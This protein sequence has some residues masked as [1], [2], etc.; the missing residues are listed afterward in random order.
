ML[1]RLCHGDKNGVTDGSH[2]TLRSLERMKGQDINNTAYI[3][4][5]AINTKTERTCTY[6]QTT[7]TRKLWPKAQGTEMP[8]AVASY[9]RGKRDG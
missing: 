3:Y 8:D 2:V 6:L 4:G 9:Q 7:K 1:L 5:R